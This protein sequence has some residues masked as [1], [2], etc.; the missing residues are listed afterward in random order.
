MDEVIQKL[1]QQNQALVNDI[2]QTNEYRGNNVD[3][4]LWDQLARKSGQ[5]GP[6]YDYGLGQLRHIDSRGHGSDLGKLPNHPTFSNLSAY[7][8]KDFP[9]GNWDINNTTGLGT[10]TPSER[11]IAEGGLKKLQWLVDHNKTGHN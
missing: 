3:Y 10:F 2:K 5:V 4:A 1:V 11:Q 6:D 7:T 8:T 9:G